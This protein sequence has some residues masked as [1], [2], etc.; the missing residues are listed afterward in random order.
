[1]KNKKPVKSDYIGRL[2]TYK[3]WA[4]THLKFYGLEED[5]YIIPYIDSLEDAIDRR[6]F[7]LMNPSGKKEK[8]QEDKMRKRKTFISIWKKR[9]LLLVDQ[10]YHS[11]S[12]KDI[13]IIDT[14]I[15]GIDETE[16]TVPL[17]LDWFY[18]VYCEN[19]KNEAMMPPN[20]TFSSSSHIMGKFLY[21]NKAKIKEV[22]EEK[23]KD[24]EKINLFQRA[25][26]LKRKS[27]DTEI[28]TLLSDFRDN[29]IG[30]NKFRI[31]IITKEKAF[32]KRYK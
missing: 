14:L 29:K 2:E 27:G 28:S 17:F 16:M 11:I 5:D 18:D 9:Y 21:Q 8:E 1:M 20:L 31:K 6:I 15:K 22:K 19:P 30:I 25:K 32:N 24:I 10:E 3:T 26:E 4:R 23:K 7:D 13:K 12:P